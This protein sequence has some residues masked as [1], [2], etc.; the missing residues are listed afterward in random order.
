MT[1][2]VTTPGPVSTTTEFVGTSTVTEPGVT[3]YETVTDTITHTET[4]TVTNNQ[5]VTSTVTSTDTQTLQVTTTVTADDCSNTGTSDGLD[6]GSCSDPT[7]NWLYGLDGR[8]EYS[9]TTNNQD[10]FP[11]GSSPTIDSPADLI[12]NRLRSPCNAPQATIDQCYAAESA[13]ASLSG[14]EAADTWNDLMT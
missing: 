11:F 14:Q 1:T 8:T 7:I 2:T 10:D 13:V 3:E 6:Y 4:S 12:C 5:V 9:Y